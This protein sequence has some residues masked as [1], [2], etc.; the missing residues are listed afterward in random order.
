MKGPEQRPHAEQ[1]RPSSRATPG[2]EGQVIQLIVFKLSDEEFGA[3]D[4]DVQRVLDEAVAFAEA[5][6][7]LPPERLYEDVYAD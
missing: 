7:E 5:G 6:A 2:A 4:A 3:V 1:A